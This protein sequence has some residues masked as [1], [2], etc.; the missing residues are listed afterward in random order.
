MA[1]VE[2]AIMFRIWKLDELGNGSR[3]AEKSESWKLRRARLWQHHHS[4]GAVP[5]RVVDSTHQEQGQW[6]ISILASRIE[7]DRCNQRTN[8]NASG[9]GVSRRAAVVDYT[10]GVVATQTNSNVKFPVVT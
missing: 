6:A 4:A 3:E 10:V 9:I 5:P 7:A 2:T 1:A 8:I